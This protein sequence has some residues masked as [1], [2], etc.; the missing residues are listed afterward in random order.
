MANFETLCKDK[1]VIT[2]P[3]PNVLVMRGASCITGSSLG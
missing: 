1:N 2:A 3:K